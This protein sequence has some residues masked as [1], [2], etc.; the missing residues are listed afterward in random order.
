MFLVVGLLAA[1]HDRTR[2]GVGQVVDAAMIDGASSL[3]SLVRS[4][5]HAGRWSDERLTN[6]LDGSAP[7]YRAYACRD[8]RFV[9]VGALEDVF[10][11]RFVDGLGLDP[12]DLSNRWDRG[13]WPGLTELFAD[14]LRTRDRD[15]WAEAFRGLD[16]CL[17]P[18]LTLDEATETEH[19][20]HRE[21]SVA[22]GSV[23]M[24]AP[25]PRLAWAGGA[26]PPL[27]HVDLDA[28][29]ACWA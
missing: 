15:A 23:T 26:A 4:W 19:A 6:L 8:G 17:S 11:D 13:Q 9:A 24:P 20:R 7:F 2:T 14:I 28:V 27:T 12:D 10:Y 22:S 29:T 5:R 16:A 18:V 25:A 3:T 21:A 1:L